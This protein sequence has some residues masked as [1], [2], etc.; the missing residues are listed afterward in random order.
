M[1]LTLLSPAKSLFPAYRAQHVERRRFEPFRA[2][3]PR[4]FERLD[5]AAGESEEHLKNNVADFLK[6]A[7]YGNGFYLNTRDRQDLAIHNGPTA[8]DPVGVII[9]AKK[10][11]NKAEMISAAKPNAKALHELLRYYLNERQLGANRDIKRLVVTNIEEW[12]VFDAADFERR[13]YSNAKL[14]KNF[15]DWHEKRLGAGNTDWFYKEIAAPFFEQDFGDISCTYFR[16]ADYR[17]AAANADAT[18]DDSLLDLY[19]ILS[20]EHLLKKPFS[21]DAN[22]L[23]KPFYDELLYLLGLEE[24]KDGGKKL[25]QRAEKRR[26]EGSLLE[27]TLNKLDVTGKWRKAPELHAYGD[28]EAAARFSIALELCITWLNRILFLKLLEG[29]LKRWRPDDPLSRFLR[30]DFI[31]DFDDLHEL[32]FEVLNRPFDQRIPTVQARYG[33]LPYLNSSLFEITPLEDAVFSVNELKDRLELPL[34]PQTALRDP[35]GQRRTGRHNTLH[36]LLEFLDAYDFSSDGKAR[37][38]AEQRD[39]INASVLGLIF[40]KI[41]GYRDGS[42]FTP[43]FITMYM[44]RETLRR[45]VVQKFNAAYGWACPDFDALYNHL[46]P[47]KIGEYNALLNSLRCC[48]P[49]VGSGHFLVSALNE[50]IAIKSELGLLADRQGRRLREL[51]AT[52]GNDELLL[53]D[54][55][56]D[57]PFEYR[58]GI[59]ASQRVQEALFH[60]K[61]TLIENC[62][63]GVD[64]NPKSV[65]ICQLRLWIELL[66]NAYFTSLPP[67]PA[68]GGGD[69]PALGPLETL[70]NIDI[71]IKC[72]NSLVSR[73][74]LDEDLSEVFRRQKFSRAD[75]LNAVQAYKQVRSKEG[76]EE[77]RAFIQRIKNEFRQTVF[78]RNPFVRQLSQKRGQLVLLDNNLDL[79]GEARK[80]AATVEKERRKLDAEIAALEQQLDDYKTGPLYRNSFEWR[81]EFP[82]VLDEAGDFR[83]FDVVVGNPPYIRQE[84][85]GAFKN[86]FQSAFAT[87]AGTAD[88]YVYFVERGMK[89]LAPGGRFSYILPNKWMRAGY[90]DKLRQF[91]KHQCRVEGITDF[92]DLPVF[93]EATTYPC[94]LELQR[95]EPAERFPAALV[96]TLQF[97]NSLADY[98]PARRFSVGL[99]GLQDGGWTLS[100]Q[101]VQNL[102]DKLRR[103]G[104]PLGEYVEGKIYYG[105]KTGLNEAFVI[106]AATRERLIAEDPKSAEVIKPFLAGREIKRYQAANTEQYLIVFEKGRTNRDLGKV[107]PE[108]WLKSN[109]PSIY[110]HLKQYEEKAK[111]RYD[112]GDYWWELRACD[113]YSEFEKEKIF[114]AEISTE[115]QFNLDEDGKYCDTTGYILGV[116]SKYV[117]GILN[118]KLVTFFFSFVSSSIRG[119]FLRWKRQYVEIIPIPDIEIQKQEPLTT[120]VTRILAL[121]RSD[122]Q[123][124]TRAEEAEIDRLVYGL[125]GLTEEEVRLVEGG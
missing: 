104:T 70:P 38:Q 83:G 52:V 11:G 99:G 54:T 66:K 49:A 6:G 45:A 17:S 23:N 14:L 77:L 81:F 108:D 65:M 60:E 21:N 41:N 35:A 102:L 113:Y 112:Q 125:Y 118:S 119:G 4:L 72:G 124:D 53:T 95:A 64:I 26:Q 1:N 37:I 110:S 69:A 114:F 117:L 87:Y 61:Q 20:P 57:Q 55:D 51:R 43:G 42:F 82:E 34:L 123:A 67:T 91:V 18:D 22:A 16:L 39:V 103:A 74:A 44:C 122:P 79:F 93:E 56:T 105:I 106:D 2:E 12:F 19:K 33:R 27:N 5:H 75:Y 116:N 76:K 96:D 30:P 46:D 90:G 94:I 109:Y 71:N 24:V 107:M 10:P 13:V 68:K 80:D 97:D 7:W 101:T 3:L 15:T 115:G 100:D 31:R 63:F 29:Q 25:I 62:L 84:E 47:G 50:L 59:A 85:L 28:T 88:L 73:F 111:K 32:F 89:V 121:K 8:K 48:D 58:P 86:H 40:E 120:L 92:G 98:L 36:Y 9:E 78:N